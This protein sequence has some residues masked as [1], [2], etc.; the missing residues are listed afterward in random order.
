MFKNSKFLFYFSLF[1]AKISL[2][3]ID[4]SEFLTENIQYSQTSDNQQHE[5]KEDEFLT[6]NN[7]EQSVQQVSETS[8]THINQATEV[9][10]SSEDN[11][12]PDNSL[13]E[14]EQEEESLYE[15]IKRSKFLKGLLAGALAQVVIEALRNTL[16]E[17][18][19]L[20]SQTGLCRD[21]LTAAAILTSG[22]AIYYFLD[23]QSISLAGLAGVLTGSIQ[24][25][26][27]R[28]L[29]GYDAHKLKRLS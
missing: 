23:N 3:Q 15:Q 21:R 9:E 26:L 22:T 29:L 6:I 19:N 25:A 16:P 28:K 7:Q 13:Q 2:C 10:S 14:T 18:Q 1:F 20:Y 11:Q 17:Q 8:E 4:Q 24:T 27:I 12:D 5:P